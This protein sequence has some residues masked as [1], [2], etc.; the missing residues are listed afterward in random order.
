AAKIRD[1]P[2]YKEYVAEDTP[3]TCGL[4]RAW[5]G[6]YLLSFE[7]T[8][9]E[10]TEDSKSMAHTT[11]PE[12]WVEYAIVEQETQHIAFVE[13]N[14]EAVELSGCL[15]LQPDGQGCYQAQVTL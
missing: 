9:S 10:A 12:V 1:E 15:A 6:E 3:L 7:V 2:I 11:G 5:Q 8:D 13:R 14:G 4:R